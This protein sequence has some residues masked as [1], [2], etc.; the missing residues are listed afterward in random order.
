MNNCMNLMSCVVFTAWYFI[1]WGKTCYCPT[2]ERLRS[3]PDWEEY[4]PMKYGVFFS[5]P[6]GEKSGETHQTQHVKLSLFGV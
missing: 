4:V 5:D 3:S 6:E 1:Q 2:W